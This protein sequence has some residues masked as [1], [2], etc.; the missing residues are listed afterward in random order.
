MIHNMYNK[1]V[2]IEK[3]E[4]SGGY[5]LYLV[6][7]SIIRAQMPVTLMF[8]I[9]YDKAAMGEPEQ[10]HSDRKVCQARLLSYGACTNG[11]RVGNICEHSVSRLFVA[12]AKFL[13]VKW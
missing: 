12:L 7:M 6:A 8:Q 9:M 10:R 3:P 1:S 13:L 4:P 2:I 11:P 5:P